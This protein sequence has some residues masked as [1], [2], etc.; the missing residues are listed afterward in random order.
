LALLNP[1]PVLAT[2][3]MMWLAFHAIA[4]FGP[5]P[6][7]DL[8]A[9]LRP[10]G[11]RAPDE[12]KSGG[13]SAARVAV[14]HLR[15]LGLVEGGDGLTVAA[16]AGK[17]DS[18]VVFC[19]VLRAAVLSTAT[20]DAPLD[21]A[22]A[23]DVLRALAWLLAGDPVGE[24][25]TEGRAAQEAAPVG[26]AVFVNPTRFNAFR[27]WCESLGLAERAVLPRGLRTAL[28]PNPTRALR[29]FLVT[30]YAPGADVPA[31]R[32]LDEL[33]SA[34]PVLPGG[35]TSRALGYPS[36]PREVDRATTYAL[37]CGQARGWLS[38][39]RRADATDTVLL[40][41]LEGGSPRTI[42]NVVVEAVS[43]V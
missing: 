10:P 22:G 32:L 7:E 2:P 5:L 8:H 14:R 21:E 30:T 37:E 35:A 29:D 41:S 19:T 27:F 43:D 38:L 1:S 4:E 6:E 13:P 24:P 31:S 3:E 39:T 12:Q 11:I 15:D 34:V 42:S 40:P 16:S 9:L 36:G 17:P 25:W 20:A 18:F 23:N 28:L 26:V 33:R